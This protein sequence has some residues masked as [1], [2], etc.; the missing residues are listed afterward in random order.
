[1]PILGRGALAFRPLRPA[2]GVSGF[3]C[4]TLMMPAGKRI[5]QKFSPGENWNFQALGAPGEWVPPVRE[6]ALGFS[7]EGI[8]FFKGLELLQIGAARGLCSPEGGVEV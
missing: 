5:M 8:L 7:G 3:P 2:C 4:G 6:N 1:M